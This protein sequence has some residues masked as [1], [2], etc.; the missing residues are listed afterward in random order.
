MLYLL[1]IFVPPLAVL[2]A[3]GRPFLAI[4]NFFLCLLLWIPGVIHA[5]FVVSEHK[6]NERAKKYGNPAS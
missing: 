3:G 4:L 2:L 6:A 1:C 5:F